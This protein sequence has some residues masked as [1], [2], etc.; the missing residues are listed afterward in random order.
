MNKGSALFPWPPEIQTDEI[1]Q[2]STPRAQSAAAASM[3]PILGKEVMARTENQANPLF[4]AC[5]SRADP[6]S[7]RRLV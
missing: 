6:I 5:R 2:K 3:Q 7:G 4:A 1:G